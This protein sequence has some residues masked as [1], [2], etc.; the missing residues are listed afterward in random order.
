MNDSIKK[1]WFCWANTQ[2]SR[3]FLYKHFHILIFGKTAF[4]LHL[5]NDNKIER[6]H[7]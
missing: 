1:Y 4:H 5:R 6:A 7:T 2:R 3:F